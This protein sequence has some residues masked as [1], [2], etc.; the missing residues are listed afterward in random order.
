MLA[1]INSRNPV[2][3]QLEHQELKINEI[4][5][6]GDQTV[7]QNNIKS[8]YNA[9][10]QLL[11][12]L[13]KDLYSGSELY[14]IQRTSEMAVESTYY[15]KPLLSPGNT[16]PPSNE[17]VGNKAIN[18][19]T[20]TTMS[21]PPAVERCTATECHECG[22]LDIVEDWQNGHDVC[23]GC[24]LVLRE[25]IVDVASEWRTFE[26]DHPK[27]DRSRASTATNEFTELAMRAKAAQM[28]GL[29]K[30]GIVKQKK[31]NVTNSRD[32]TILRAIE[33]IERVASKLCVH[34][35]AVL[36]AKEFFKVYVD[37]LAAKARQGH[38]FGTDGRSAPLKA[39]FVS[40]VIA[41]S[42]YLG[43]RVAR[44]VRS[45]KDIIAATELTKKQISGIIQKMTAVI[46]EAAHNSTTAHEFADHFA[47]LIGLTR[48]QR[49]AALDVTERVTRHEPL[50][51]SSPVSLAA[52]AVYIVCSLANYETA[53]KRTKVTTIS[54]VSRSAINRALELM[55]PA[56]DRFI[57][58]SFVHQ[59]PLSEFN[60]K[61]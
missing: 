30:K 55:Q 39:G 59:V 48:E 33:D 2:K 15:T 14:G 20:S 36:R 13:C 6:V 56:F 21:R 44:V 38:H 10:P 7:S 4:V 17:T 45:V 40:Q 43:C 58:E 42:L 26:E 16:K 61:V 9:R 37:H 11:N 32:V 29:R 49:T 8:P 18:G 3:T 47:A 41:G 57:P 22:S 5:N 12:E 52:V 24:G 27:D 51:G 53:A 50:L 35:A 25:R 1:E 34:G 54:D 60:S 46:P 23:R 28:H 19:W 31:L